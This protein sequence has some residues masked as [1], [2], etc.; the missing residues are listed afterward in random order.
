M[1]KSLRTLVNMTQMLSVSSLKAEEATK[2]KGDFLANMSHEIRTPMN[3]IIGM[4]YLALQTELDRKQRNYIAKVHR[5]GESLLGIINDILDFSKIEAG[6]LDM[7]ST[8]FWL[9]DVFDNLSN[10]VGLTAEDKGLELMFNLPSDLPTALIGD[11]LR[12]GQVLVNLGNNAVKFTDEGGEITITAVVSEETADTVTLQFSIRDSGIGMTA[13]QQSKLFQSFSQADTSTSRKYGGTGLGLAI[14]KNLTEMMGGKIWLES[15]VYKGT[16]FHFTAQFGKQQR[17]MPQP[18]S[19][20]SILGD[21]RILVVDDNATAR[22]ILTNMLLSFGL[23]VDQA[24][25]GDEALAILENADEQDSYKLV[26]MDWKMPGQNGLEITRAIQNDKA[27]CEIPTV[28]MVT[29]YGREEARL[30]C[31]SRISPGI[32]G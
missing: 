30:A 17:E 29:A 18:R 22:D 10:L 3:A 5:S 23:R 1:L 32:S 16:T 20:A 9:E 4:S 15:E 25:N 14:S 21:L 19:R 7:E 27:L 12:L 13:E 26:L 11:P 8:D 28:I 24:S 2:A 31:Y 6:K